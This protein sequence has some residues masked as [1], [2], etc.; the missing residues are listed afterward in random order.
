MLTQRS[1]SGRIVSGRRRNRRIGRSA[2]K[3]AGETCCLFWMWSR[4]CGGARIIGARWRFSAAGSCRRQLDS[5]Q[6]QLDGSHCIDNSRRSRAARPHCLKTGK[7]YAIRV[8]AANL[9]RKIHAKEQVAPVLHRTA[10][11]VSADRP[12]RHEIAGQER[13]GPRLHRCRPVCNH[14]RNGFQNRFPS[15]NVS[16]SAATQNTTVNRITR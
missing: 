15:A 6:Y 1:G 11:R 16:T 10:G 8:C 14:H 4:I 13:C 12:V 9:S 3:A 7:I 5:M 2:A